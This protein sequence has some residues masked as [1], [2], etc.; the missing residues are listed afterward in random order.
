MGWRITREEALR[1]RGSV[2]GEWKSDH[3]S[4]PELLGRCGQCQQGTWLDVGLIESSREESDL[5]EEPNVRD[6]CPVK[7]ETICRAFSHWI[8]F[9]GR[10]RAFLGMRGWE[11]SNQQF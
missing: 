5:E 7:R 9:R 10:Q 4:A 11:R 2:T 3:L 8:G 1:G 6:K